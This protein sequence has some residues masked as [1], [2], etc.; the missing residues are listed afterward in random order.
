MTWLLFMAGWLIAAAV[1]A[2]VLGRAIR[3]A[4]EDAE[5]DARY[6]RALGEAEARRRDSLRRIV[7]GE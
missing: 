1:I 6:R 3:I 5:A 2:V 7:E 4:D